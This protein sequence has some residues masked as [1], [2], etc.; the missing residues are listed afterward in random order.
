MSDVN[1]V[2]LSGGLTRDP[3]LHETDGGSHVLKFGLGVSETFVARDGQK[4]ERSHYVDVAV[5]GNRAVSLSKILRKGM[6]V[7][8]QGHLSYS[9]WEKDGQKRS[10]VEVIADE[11]A[12][13]R[14][15]KSEAQAAPQQPQAAPSQAESLP[16]QQESAQQPQAYQGTLYGP[17][18]Y[19]SMG[20]RRPDAPPAPP[21]EY[22]DPYYGY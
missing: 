12:L 17:S 9:T 11:I 19:N 22:V 13:P 3:E 16:W 2:C 14:K 1:V 7:T 4:A 5:F 8:I 20:Y 10:K 15:P 6:K 18:E 21:A